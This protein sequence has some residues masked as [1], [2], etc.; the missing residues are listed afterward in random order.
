MSTPPVPYQSFY[1]VVTT[2]LG[3]LAQKASMPVTANTIKT[4]MLFSP[5]PT[6]TAPL[7]VA[8]AVAVVG[9]EVEVTA[10]AARIV[11]VLV[12]VLVSTTLDPSIPVVVAV[13]TLVL[14]VRPV[15]WLPDAVMV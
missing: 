9:L 11:A 13:T 14:V 2:F 1:S 7:G 15:V 5:P 3:L 8:E 10:A 12:S 4:P 6:L